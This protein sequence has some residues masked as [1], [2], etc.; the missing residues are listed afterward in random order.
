MKRIKLGLFFDVVV[1]SQPLEVQ[2]VQKKTINPYSHSHRFL[3]V[4]MMIVRTSVWRGNHI[5]SL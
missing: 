5:I 1:L 4:G 2:R 3:Q